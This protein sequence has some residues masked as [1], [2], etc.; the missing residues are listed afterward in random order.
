MFDQGYLRGSARRV[1][2]LR[3]VLSSA[4]H[5]FSNAILSFFREP[6]RLAHTGTSG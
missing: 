6:T 3:P 2:E 1:V 4:P 5:R